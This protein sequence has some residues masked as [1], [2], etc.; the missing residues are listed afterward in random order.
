MSAKSGL[1]LLPI[2]KSVGIGPRTTWCSLVI[3]GPEMKR[4]VRASKPIATRQNVKREAKRLSVFR[5][6]YEHTPPV[7][8]PFA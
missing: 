6:N 5:L 3:N 8:P 1:G 4:R 2:D 7:N